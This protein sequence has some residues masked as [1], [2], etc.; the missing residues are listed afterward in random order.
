MS[1]LPPY[2]ELSWTVANPLGAA[3][4]AFCVYASPAVSPAPPFKL[5]GYIDVPPWTTPAVVEAQ[6]TSFRDYMAGWNAAGSPWGAGW[7]YIVTHKNNHNMESKLYGA[8]VVRGA[9]NADDVHWFTCNEAPYLNCPANIR[10]INSKDNSDPTEV[11]DG[12]SG[13]NYAFTRTQLERAGRIS[14]LDWYYHSLTDLSEER[15][16]WPKA[17]AETGQT[18]ALLVPRGD[19]Y[20]GTLKNVTAER[21]GDE[22]TTVRAEGDFVETADWG[23]SWYNL[24]CGLILNGTSQYARTSHTTALDPGTEEFTLVQAAAFPGTNGKVHLSKRAAGDGY[25]FK[26]SAANTF[27]FFVDGASGSDAVADATASWFDGKV[28][29]AIGS[30]GTEPGAAR[31]LKLYYDGILKAAKLVANLGAVANTDP[32]DAGTDG[33][34]LFSALTPLRA[35]ALYKRRLTDDE[36][37]QA[38]GYL[39]GWSGYKMPG[40]AEMFYD[41]RD[42]RCWSGYGSVLEDLSGNFRR[43]AII[44][45]PTTRGAPWRLRELD[46]LT[47]VV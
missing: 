10:S 7:R 4:K 21:T 3:F 29:V 25:E 24:P 33:G 9:P 13:R 12:L 30:Y 31:A 14:S 16:R 5:I 2:N 15:L 40:G 17:I 39:R 44:G 20:V 34:A 43:G 23:T 38:T 42:D 18:V 27:Q 28:H 8:T 46:T 19:R 6:C 36:A 22:G 47:P 11:I 32:L 45:S 1:V 26:N 35:W 41:L 37:L